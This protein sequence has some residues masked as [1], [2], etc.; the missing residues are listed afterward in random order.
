MSL[1][2]APL[3]EGNHGDAALVGEAQNLHDLVAALRKDH[4]VRRVRGMVSK[5]SPAVTF[6]FFPAG[7]DLVF[8]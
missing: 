1:E 3:P 6:E 7:E 4:G 8:R 2:A 5:E